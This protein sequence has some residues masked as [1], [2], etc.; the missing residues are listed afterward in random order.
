MQTFHVAPPIMPLLQT[1]R[2]IAISNKGQ[3]GEEDDYLGTFRWLM[4]L[5]FRSS[6]IIQFRSY[7]MPADLI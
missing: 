4:N 7:A 5:P 6:T 3:H 2:Q 1:Q